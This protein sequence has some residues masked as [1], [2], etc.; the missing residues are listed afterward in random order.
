VHRTRIEVKGEEIM[1]LVE[2]RLIMLV[3]I[4]VLF[5]F[6]FSMLR[7]RKLDIKYCLVWL[8]GLLG[9]AVFCAFPRLLDI[10]SNI[11]GIHTPVFTL[12]MI[13]IAFL[14]CI[15][16]SLTIVVSR[17]SDR[18]HKLTQNIAIMEF[19]NGKASASLERKKNDA[20]DAKEK[21]DE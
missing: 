4:I 7:R 13:C 3:I 20:C 2:L 17:L 6:F 21:H 1:V 15:S 19:E 12:F 14:S 18:L 9:I 5:I 8:F 10:L 11:L 16:I